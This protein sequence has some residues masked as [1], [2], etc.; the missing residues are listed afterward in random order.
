MVA[1]LLRPLYGGGFWPAFAQLVA[2][3]Y[4]VAYVMHA[5]VP[6]LARVRPIQP[7]KRPPGEPL[8]DAAASLGPLAVKALYWVAVEE[9]HRRGVGKLY[10]GPIVGVRGWL[11]VALCVVL[12]DHLHDAWFYWTHRLLHWRPLYRWVHWEH[13][14]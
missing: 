12:M 11:Y 6:A 9:M 14:R 5:V 10:A 1:S 2:F 7:D 13:H 4:P 8:R 3:Y